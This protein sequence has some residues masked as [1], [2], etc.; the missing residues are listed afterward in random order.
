MH[1]VYLYS[2]RSREGAVTMEMTT[3]Y[4]Y[5]NTKL[6]GKKT[7]EKAYLFKRTAGPLSVR[8]STAGMTLRAA[9][10]PITRHL[11]FILV[12]VCADECVY[13]VVHGGRFYAGSALQVAGIVMRAA[14]LVVLTA[15][16]LKLKHLK[17]NKNK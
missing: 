17:K 7:N 11:I 1:S 10:C 12:R 3:S 16:R 2:E 8:C 15:H 4:Y 13:D 5:R 14:V 9:S 6:G